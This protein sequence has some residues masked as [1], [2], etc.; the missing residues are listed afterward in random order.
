[1]QV[2][3]PART[4]PAY[5]FTGDPKYL[6]LPPPAIESSTLVSSDHALRW[7]TEVVSTF[8]FF[9]PE[10]GLYGLAATVVLD[11]S[12]RFAF[13]LRLRAGLSYGRHETSVGDA[14]VIAGG[15]RVS[16]VYGRSVLHGSW[17][18]SIGP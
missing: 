6:G 3:R 11:F 15:G 1:M 4:P 17:L 12:D 13:Q 9:F 18:C 10:Q 5:W 8:G 2:W 16:A 14:N 7:R